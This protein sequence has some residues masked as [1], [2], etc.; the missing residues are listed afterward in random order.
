MF[1]T[2]KINQEYDNIREVIINDKNKLK[3]I[4]FNKCAITNEILYYKDRL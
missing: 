4:T 2:N 3:D 1:K